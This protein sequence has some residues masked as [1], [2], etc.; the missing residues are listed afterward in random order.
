MAFRVLS[1]LLKT[2]QKLQSSS[3]DQF[4][5]IVS[6]DVL[7]RCMNTVLANWEHPARQIS[8][9]MGDL[10]GILL[11]I[12]ESSAAGAGS[13]SSSADWKGL[14]L[15]LLAQPSGRKAK[16]LALSQVIPRVSPEVSLPSF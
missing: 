8:A 13:L 2:F 11:E 15:N 3:P 9:Q 6:K 7:D 14:L 16:Y 1:S 4:A 10:F 5:I 12:N